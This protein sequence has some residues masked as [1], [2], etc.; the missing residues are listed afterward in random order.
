R[1]NKS[2]PFFLSKSGLKSL[3]I[4]AKDDITGLPKTY[5]WEV[6]MKSI[7]EKKI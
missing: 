1:E 7:R 3:T 4:Q 2:V 5:Y 6:G